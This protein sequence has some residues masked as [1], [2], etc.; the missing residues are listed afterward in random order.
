MFEKHA[1]SVLSA[2]CLALL[3]WVGATV[4]SLEKGQVRQETLMSGVKN[5][6]SDLKNQFNSRGEVMQQHGQR[7]NALEIRVE[8]LERDDDR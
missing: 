7:I 8:R 5:E 3:L 1:P 2:V 6:L 4:S